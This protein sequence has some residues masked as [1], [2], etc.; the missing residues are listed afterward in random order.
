MGEGREG[1]QGEMERWEKWEIV[2][3]FMRMIEVA[4]HMHTHNFFSE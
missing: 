4:T 3:I 2:S 1:G